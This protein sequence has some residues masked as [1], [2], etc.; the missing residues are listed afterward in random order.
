M[1]QAKQQI[2]PLTSSERIVLLDSLRGI[3]VL[4]IL[5]MNIPGFGLPHIRVEDYT[6]NNESGLNY[7]VWYVFGPGVLEGSQRAIFSMLFGA[8]TLIFIS[9]LEKRTSGLMPAELFF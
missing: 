7:Y 9:R 2:G 6:I 8:G 4:G 5:L 1:T 3:A